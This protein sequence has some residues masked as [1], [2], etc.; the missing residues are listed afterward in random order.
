M[1]PSHTSDPVAQPTFE[2]ATPL[3]NFVAELERLHDDEHD[4]GRLVTGVQ[5]HLTALLAEP[6]LLTPKQR[7]PWTNRYRPHLLAVA[8]SRRFSVVALVWL[9]GQSTPIHDH[10]C[11]CVV[12]VYEGIEREQ[13]FS[14][15]EDEQGNRWLLPLTDEYVLPGQASALVPPEENIHQV[16]NAGTDLAISIHVYGADLSAQP[17][18]PPSSVNQCFDDVPIRADGRAGHPVPWRHA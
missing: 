15:R 9:P 18:G 13:R 16:R 8:P 1:H 2:L 4:P 17:S 12:G 5:G 11:W 10:I 3:A 14:L 6:A 7:E